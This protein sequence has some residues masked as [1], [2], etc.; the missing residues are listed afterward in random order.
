MLA[1]RRDGNLER[2]SALYKPGQFVTRDLR[3][4]VSCRRSAF[5][6]ESCVRGEQSCNRP[7]LNPAMGRFDNRQLDATVADDHGDPEEP[8]AKLDEAEKQAAALRDQL[9][10]VLAEALLR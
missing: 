2:Q 9:K 8:L 7:I 3:L 1:R 4:P 6:G 10:V 5:A